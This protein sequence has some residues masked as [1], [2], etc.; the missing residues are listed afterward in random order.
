LTIEE[1]RAYVERLLPLFKNPKDSNLTTLSAAARGI[2][3]S[4]FFPKQVLARRLPSPPSPDPYGRS[5]F[6]PIVPSDDVISSAY[7][8]FGDEVECA[9]IA[10]EERVREIQG[11]DKMPW[12]DVR[13]LVLCAIAKFDRDQP[14]MVAQTSQ[15]QNELALSYGQIFRAIEELAS[16]GL[17]SVTN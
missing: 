7:I 16:D 8:A 14:G 1:I 6:R 11:N 4:G 13:G 12:D 3:G 17:I 9:L 5:R 2:A 15:L 10:L